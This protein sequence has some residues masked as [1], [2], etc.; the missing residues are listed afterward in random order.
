M[1]IVY[2]NCSSL[3]SDTFFKLTFDTLVMFL[4]EKKNVRDSK[5]VCSSKEKIATH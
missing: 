1:D 4:M 3:T 5:T 2:F